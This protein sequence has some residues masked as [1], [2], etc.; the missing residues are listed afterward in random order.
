VPYINTDYRFSDGTLVTL[1]DQS[2]NFNNTILSDTRFG[3][4]AELMGEINHVNFSDW[5]F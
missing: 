4:Q 1:V 2:F 5:S 3:T